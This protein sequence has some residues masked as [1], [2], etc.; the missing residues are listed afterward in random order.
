MIIDWTRGHILIKA[1][2]KFVTV[3]S[4][5]LNPEHSGFSF[6][7]YLNFIQKYNK[8]LENEL[9]NENSK[10]RII[11]IIKDYAIKNSIKKEGISQTSGSDPFG[12]I[13]LNILR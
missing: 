13:L 9:I 12:D 6:V 11:S 4:E 2:E 7:V 1:D 10:N 8:P 5:A 3:Y